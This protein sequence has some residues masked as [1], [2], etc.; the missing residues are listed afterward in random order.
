[1]VTSVV[2]IV[3]DFNREFSL[4]ILSCAV[5]L[6][7]SVDLRNFWWFT[8]AGLHE[9]SLLCSFSFVARDF[10]SLFLAQ[11]VPVGLSPS[12]ASSS[13]FSYGTASGPFEYFFR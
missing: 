9:I 11:P 4:L 8:V 6:F 10:R 3:L 12:R 7:F 2:V 1:M 5:H 13:F